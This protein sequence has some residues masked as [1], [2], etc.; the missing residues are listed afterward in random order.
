VEPSDLELLDRWRAGDA[1]AGK[2]LVA[3]YFDSV[4]RFFDTKC[5]READ[6]LVQATFLACVNAKDTF[7]HDASFRT[8][9]FAIARNILYRFFRTSHRDGE[10]LDFE[11][12]SLRDLVTTPA[13]KLDRGAEY[14]KL[15]AALRRLPLAQQALLELFYWEGMGIDELAAIFEAPDVTIRSRLYRARGALRA[16]IE[17]DPEM[18]REIAASP[19]SLDSWARGVKRA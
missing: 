1:T 6:D 2:A 7:R 8:Y 9:L 19:D 18:P 13:T 14:G 5:E 12:S 10:R 16:L 17:D 3:R 15:L 4:Y 11:V